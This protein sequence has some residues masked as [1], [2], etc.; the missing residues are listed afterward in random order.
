MTQTDRRRRYDTR[1]FRAEL[2]QLS[3]DEIRRRL[4]SNR[5]RSLERRAI[6]EEVLRQRAAATTGA[7]AGEYAAPAEPEAVA[8]EAAA[9][10]AS[11][12]PAMAKLRQGV[13]DAIKRTRQEDVPTA[14]RL[15]RTLGTIL[16][17]GGAVAL[18]AGLLRR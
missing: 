4:N 13:A 11:S 1:R 17:L 10:A 2:A 15:G 12:G 8:G 7:V 6:A 16:V 9:T 5:I 3:S 14:R 18:V